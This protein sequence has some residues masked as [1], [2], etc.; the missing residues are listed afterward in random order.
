[1]LPGLVEAVGHQLQA[2]VLESGQGLPGHPGD[3]H[4]PL[5]GHQGLDRLAA[6]L[7]VADVVDVGL[8]LDE[9]A[10][11]RQAL[12][13]FGAGLG[14]VEPGEVRPRLG[15]HPA[16]AVDDRD[17]G[18]TV[19][20]AELEVEGVVEG[21]HLDQ[22]GAEL[23]FDRGVGDE[24]DPPADERQDRGTAVE[25]QVALVLGV[26]GDRG[27]AEHR[28]RPGGGD[29]DPLALRTA[30]LD[31]IGDVVELALDRPHLD[32]EI[33]DGGLQH[34][35]PVDQILA[36]ADQPLLVEAHEGLAHRLRQPLVQ[37]EA[38]ARPVAGGAEE[39]ELL[40]DVALVLLLP[41]PH[42]FEEAL[43]P[44]F[45]AARPLTAKLALDHELGGDPGVVGAGEEEGVFPQHPLPAGEEVLE[46]GH[47]GVPDVELPGDVGR[48]DH[49]AERGLLRRRLDDEV[50][51]LRPAP[52]PGGLVGPRVEPLVH[53]VLGAW[54]ACDTWGAHAAVLSF[55]W[56]AIIIRDRSFMPARGGAPAAL[57]YEEGQPGAAAL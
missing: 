43:P 23:L 37:G 50:P 46:R 47:Q 25:M 26:E 21:R 35:R 32:F 12:D 57:A 36:A 51:R 17:A 55:P 31:R 1:M 52:L 45:P 14:A 10:R 56:S 16:L 11:R 24:R 49:Q 53:L 48:R 34:R 2:A 4:E 22:A 39:V 13:H 33:G 7:A 8:D 5:G 15:R 19:T 29:D 3:V 54:G 27:V 40:A 38:L 42:P 28:L 30:P 9:E 6:A 44:E 18:E 20:A 41:V